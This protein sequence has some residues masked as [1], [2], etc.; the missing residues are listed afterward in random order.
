MI[1]QF[2]KYVEKAIPKCWISYMKIDETGMYAHV[3]YANNI[4]KKRFSQIF[5]NTDKNDGILVRL[6]HSDIE[7]PAIVGE[8]TK[9]VWGKG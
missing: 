8:N 5:P 4:N 1:I 3:V 9:V 2:R 6:S 7:N